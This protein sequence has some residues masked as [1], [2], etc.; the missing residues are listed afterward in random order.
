MRKGGREREELRNR[1][2]CREQTGGWGGG[3]AGGMGKTGDGD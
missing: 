2:N 1:L 3:V